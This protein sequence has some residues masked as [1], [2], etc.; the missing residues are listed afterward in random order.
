MD[1]YGAL[2]VTNDASPDDIRKAYKRL[3]LI[4]SASQR[5]GGRPS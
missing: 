2:E 3:V 1:H 4:V 5:S